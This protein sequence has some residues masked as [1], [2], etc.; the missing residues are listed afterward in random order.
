VAENTASWRPADIPDLTGRVAV[1]TGANSGLGYETALAF[2]EHGATVVLACRDIARGAVAADRIRASVPAASVEPIRL[3]LADL[4]SVR[5]FARQCAARHESLDILVNNAGVMAPPCRLTTKQ[6]FELQFGV[7]HLGHCALTG[8]LLPALVRSAG[9]RVVTV[10]S[11]AHESGRI[12]FDDLQLERGYTPYRGYGASKVAN[13]LFMLELDRRLRRAGAPVLSAGAHPGFAS[14]NLQAAGPFLCAKPLTSWL[15][16][17]GV[18][19][20]G[21]SAAHGAWSQ[22]YAATAAG[23]KGGDYVGPKNRIRGH[24][25]RSGMSALARD[26]AVAARLWD[27]SRQLTGVDVD[28]AIAQ[29]AA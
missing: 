3:D 1:V 22:L 29:G 10:S 24:V 7:N 4:D 18:R 6:G 12:D 20:F 2:A 23:V 19:L 25:A 26:E 13:V 14:T 11:F 9:S 16:L 17:A 8:L 5:D 15:V 27:V 28:A 21:Q